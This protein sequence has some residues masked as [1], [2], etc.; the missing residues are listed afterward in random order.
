MDKVIK[1]V[2]AGAGKP[3]RGRKPRNQNPIDTHYQAIQFEMLDCSGSLVLQ[4]NLSTKLSTCRRNKRLI[5]VDDV[6]SNNSDQ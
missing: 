2:L 3:K 1:P 6:G 5:R 4:H